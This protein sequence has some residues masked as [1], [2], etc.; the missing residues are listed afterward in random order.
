MNVKPLYDDSQLKGL[1][2]KANKYFKD[3]ADIKKPRESKIQSIGGGYL[4][5]IGLKNLGLDAEKIKID[6]SEKGKPYLSGEKIF[7]NIAHSADMVVCAFGANEIGVDIEKIKP[8]SE[9]FLDR[10][11][12]PTEKAKISAAKQ[13]VKL[14]TRKEALAKCLGTGVGENVYKTDLSE[15]QFSL[16]GTVYRL[17]SFE[18]GEYMIS[19]CTEFDFPPDEI[20]KIK[21]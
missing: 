6:V 9:K 17:K 20:V 4:F 19:V 7:F 14:W 3:R 21:I 12:L 18:V 16:D 8:L 10:I 15:D 2:L 1:Y 5:S 11:S 13:I